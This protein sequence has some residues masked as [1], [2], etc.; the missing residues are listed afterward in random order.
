MGEFDEYITGVMELSVGGKELKLTAD[1]GDK[2]K[3][4]TAYSDG[5]LTEKG[6][7]L[8][9]NT[10][11]GLLIKSYPKENPE[12]LRGFYMKYD[13]EFLQEFMIKVGWAKREDFESKKEKS[14][15]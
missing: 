1:I 8:I 10:L 12:G 15:N 13:M 3:L 4:K 5:K 9:D 6:L 2:R 7:E 14:P 11:I